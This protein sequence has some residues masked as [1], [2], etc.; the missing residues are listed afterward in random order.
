MT[1]PPKKQTK[2]TQLVGAYGHLGFE[3]RTL[4]IVSLAEL[5]DTW[6]EALKQMHAMLSEKNPP[7][8]RSVMVGGLEQGL[9]EAPVFFSSLPEAQRH[10]ALKMYRRAIEARVP[11]F[12]KR[13]QD[14]LRKVLARG[15]VKNENEWYLLRHRVDEI[16]GELSHAS[17]LEKLY[18]LL[19]DYETAA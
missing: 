13:D 7:Y 6:D 12:F 15:R 4:G 14:V 18:T 8:T 1:Q 16:E 10:A 9:R 17:E 5:A 3:L 11:D 19:G 2:F